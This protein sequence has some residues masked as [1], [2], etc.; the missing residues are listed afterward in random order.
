M[1]SRKISIPVRTPLPATLQQTPGLDL[2][3]RYQSARAGGDIFD[4]VFLKR[5]ITL[6]L[7]DIAGDRALAHPIAATVQDVFRSLSEKIFSERQVNESE[8]TATL[9]HEINRALLNVAGVGFA[10]TFLGCYNRQL[11]ILTWINAGGIA[12]LFHDS[13]GTRSLDTGGVPLG[14]FSHL[15]HEPSMQAFEPGARMLLT[16]KGL[17][18]GSRGSSAQQRAEIIARLRSAFENPALDSGREI[19]AAILKEAANHHQ[20]RRFSTLRRSEPLEDQ[21]VVALVRPFP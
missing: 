19:C 16:T 18:D 14:I 17:I 2:A 13:D 20:P 9:L 8:G 4:A 11:A 21:T 5:H 6:M 15:T 3:V 7:T 1:T 12:P 10:P